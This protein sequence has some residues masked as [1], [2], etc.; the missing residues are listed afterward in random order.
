[1]SHLDCCKRCV[2]CSSRLVGLPS[3]SRMRARGQS[4]LRFS[5]VRARGQS[6]QFPR[7]G[8]ANAPTTASHDRMLALQSEVHCTLFRWLRD[9][10]FIASLLIV[11]SEGTWRKGVARRGTMHGT[12]LHC[13]RQSRRPRGRYMGRT[14]SQSCGSGGPGPNRRIPPCADFP[15]AAVEGR[16][17]G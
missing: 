6:V 9:R 5:R 16:L 11:L 3:F 17:R 8:F 1:M 14:S 12:C 15:Y 13:L 10:D 4:V 2:S 7:D